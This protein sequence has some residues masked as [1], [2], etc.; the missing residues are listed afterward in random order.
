MST[1]KTPEQRVSKVFE[2]LQTGSRKEYIGGKITQLDHALQAAYLSKNEG[3]DE[4]TILAALL[5]NIGH[6][7]PSTEQHSGTRD[8]NE[9]TNRA[10]DIAGNYSASGGYNYY[11]EF[12]ANY[13][14]TLG[15][16]N[17]TCELIES[18]VMAKRYLLAKE[19]GYGDGAVLL[20][21][22]LKGDPL[23]PT[24]MRE[25]EKD[26]LFKQKVQLAKWDD[27]AAKA[28]GVKP[29]VLDT[30]RDMA[31]RNL[32]MSMKMLY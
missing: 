22:T 26:S 28:T 25:F 3:A 18:N 19:P 11:A 5:L 20:F 23:L 21:I 16:S 6:L 12:G 13:L 27:A 29:P 32:L 30:Y 8:K 1:N 10:F 7:I 4:E 2:L 24:E 14:R 17:K 9:A 31:I 15:F